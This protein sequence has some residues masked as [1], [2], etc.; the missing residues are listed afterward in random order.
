MGLSVRIIFMCPY[1]EII[2]YVIFFPFNI[3]KASI[4]K[5]RQRLPGYKF[6][7]LHFHIF[8]G[9][10]D[11]KASL[12]VWPFL[13]IK[14]KWCTIET[15]R[16]MNLYMVLIRTEERNSQCFSTLSIVVSLLIQKMGRK[17]RKWTH[18]DSVSSGL[19]TTVDGPFSL[20]A[21]DCL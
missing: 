17:A 16:K 10:L 5:K 14:R 2:C 13:Y 18:G 1:F 15:N 3:C 9:T 4:W 21:Q 19:S 12:W 8:I 6:P 20:P 11:H 7:N